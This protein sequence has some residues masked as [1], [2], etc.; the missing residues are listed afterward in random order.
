VRIATNSDR[1]QAYWDDLV[2][3]EFPKAPVVLESIT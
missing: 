2:R 1:L 3:R